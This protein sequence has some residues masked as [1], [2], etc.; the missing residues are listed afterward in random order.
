MSEQLTSIVA[1]DATLDTPVTTEAPKPEKTKK[2]PKK[3]RFLKGLSIYA[4]LLLA[5]GSVLLWYLNNALV[6]YEN[7][8]VE[9]ALRTYLEWIN[10]E[11]YQAIYDAA[12]FTETPLNGKE[13]YLDYLKGLYG[14][15]TELTL[16][17]KPT[18]DGTKKYSLYNGKTKLANLQ[19]MLST[20]GEGNTWYIVTE[21]S[22]LK[23]YTIIA[24][25]DVRLTVNGKSVAELSLPS[26]E[27]QSTVFPLKEEAETVLP[28]IREYTLEN[29][30]TPPT[31]EGVALSGEACTVV[32]NE[33][34]IHLYSPD[35]AAVQETNKDLAIAAATTYAE[36]VSGDASRT[37]ALK[38]IHKDSALYQTV[39]TYSSDWFGDHDSHEFR[40]I[41]VSDY[42]C[43]A[44]TD[45]SCTVSFQP[46]YTR[47]SRVIMGVPVHYEM[48]FLLNENGEWMLFAL[49]Q[50]VDAELVTDTTATTTTTTN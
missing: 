26:K 40:D 9:S 15:A 10:T 33:Q 23:P 14:G 5:V 20:E 1:E 18:V 30:L 25:D 19:A 22:Y 34:T 32:S 42:H 4:L 7:S 28:V 29:L 27:V 49:A 41:T 36:F 17:E 35:T 8:T 2:T 38:Y 48:T 13:Q 47:G 21:L 46:V 31:V 11:N 44:S 37:Q 3:G 39:R 50:A 16:R 24:S 43:F 6:R 12:G 45:F